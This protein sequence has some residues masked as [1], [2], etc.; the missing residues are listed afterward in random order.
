M[1]HFNNDD[2]RI[3]KSFTIYSFNILILLNQTQYIT[4][5]KHR[6]LQPNNYKITF[7]KIQFIA[8]RSNLQ[9]VNTLA[10][11][12]SKFKNNIFTPIFDSLLSN[13]QNKIDLW[14]NTVFLVELR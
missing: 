9:D 7:H 4:M 8:F 6:I 12:F 1:I 11:S 2:V 10:Y 5:L 14:N 3:F 13:I